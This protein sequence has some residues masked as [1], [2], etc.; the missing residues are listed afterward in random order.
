ML[1]P[2]FFNNPKRR[3]VQLISLVVVGEWSFYGIFRC[4]YAV[5]YIGCAQCP[6][7][8]CP[9]RSLW[10]WSWIL[11]L[12]SAVF[13]GRFF[14]GWVCPGGFVADIL[15]T[16]SFIRQKF[17]SGL[18]RFLNYG[19][20]L[21]LAAT[22]YF[23]FVLN[24]PRWAIPIRTG[25]FFNSVS[26]TFEH[27]ELIWIIKTIAVLAFV[28][29]G[30]GISHFWCRFF[31]PT[32]GALELFSKFSVFRYGMSEACNGCDICT[33]TCGPETK[34]AQENCTNC[35]DCQD[36]C[37]VDAIDIQS[38]VKRNKTGLVKPPGYNVP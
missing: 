22:L 11:I 34:P 35:G 17:N 5:P 23:F 19:K 27:A 13:M 16:V 10:M 18:L 38:V 9:G 3:I 28:A 21:L 20:Y 14:C 6:V 26:L 29:L 24:N 30:V 4:P 8:Q 31:C 37:P 2:G 25:D 1:K 32:G 15:G 7:V 33:E 36:G 12:L